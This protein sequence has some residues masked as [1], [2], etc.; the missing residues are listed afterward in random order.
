[1]N[2]Y[3]AA[4]SIIKMSSVTL[5]PADSYKVYQ[6]MTLGDLHNKLSNELSKVLNKDFFSL[7]EKKLED[8]YRKACYGLLSNYAQPEIYECA[9]PGEYGY[10]C[11]TGNIML[12]ATPPVDMSKVNIVIDEFIN[13]LKLIDDFDISVKM[14]ED[15]SLMAGS[16]K[17]IISINKNPSEHVGQ[18]PDLNVA[19]ANWHV[20]HKLLW[21]DSTDKED[22][23][24]GSVSPRELERRLKEAESMFKNDSSSYTKDQTD[25]H[26]LNIPHDATSDEAKDIIQEQHNNRSSIRIH[27]FGLSQRQIEGYFTSIREILEYCHKHGISSVSWS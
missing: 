6:P 2:W 7:K 16:K 22:F 21:P 27:D 26:N 10:F 3:K 11:F 24:Y 14:T 15:S 12:T 1:M 18:I 20:L 9:Q 5:S 4:Q 25:S 23:Y 19:N 17:W 13:D 8:E